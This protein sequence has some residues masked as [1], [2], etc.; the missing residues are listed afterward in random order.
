MSSELKIAQKYCKAINKDL[1]S[2]MYN[3][4]PRAIEIRND[5]IPRALTWINRR[6]WN[7]Y[8]YVENNDCLIK[9]LNW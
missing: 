5:I 1:W 2:L 8:L 6:L 4:S 3:N 9:K 7:Y